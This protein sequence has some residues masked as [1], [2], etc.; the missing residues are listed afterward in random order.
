MSTAPVAQGG[1]RRQDT[2]GLLV[3][4]VTVLLG[5]AGRMV[6]RA[7]VGWRQQAS[8]ARRTGLISNGL[9]LGA[10]MGRALTGSSGRSRLLA[11]EERLTLGPK[12][13]LYVIRCGERRLLVASA[14]EAALQ[15]MQLPLEDTAQTQKECEN[16]LPGLAGMEGVTQG[17]RR[18]A[19]RNPPRNPQMGA[20]A[21]AG[22]A[23]VRSHG[24]DADEGW[25][26][27]VQ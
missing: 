17:A 3:D 8:A 5:R 24:V 18:S 1:V 7:W 25:S 22:K 14:G 15:W 20:K 27:G 10:V 13:H 16:T 11:L 4:R 12:Q 19:Q 2:R 26:G 23:R 9:G 6:R 21:R